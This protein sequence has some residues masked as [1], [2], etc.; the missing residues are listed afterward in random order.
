MGLERRWGQGKPKMIAAPFATLR[1]LK[2]LVVGPL[3][4]CLLGVINLMTTP[5]HWWVKWP[6]LGIGVAWVISLLRV[7]RAAVVVGGLA[8]LVALLLRR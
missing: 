2:F 3:V 7:L 8:A 6:A 1:A 4:L 5:G